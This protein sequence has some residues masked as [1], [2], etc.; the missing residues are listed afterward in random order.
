MKKMVFLL[1]GLV[2]ASTAAFAHPPSDIKIQFD[3]N[4]KT[5]TAVIQHRVSN[6]QSHFIKKV[7]IGLNGREVQ[8]LPFAKQD[9]NATQTVKITIPEAKKG[10]VLSV[11]GYCNLSGRLEKEIKIS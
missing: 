3:D 7:D 10:D 6:P 5:L 1:I 9:N 11:E 4:T 2:V 8:M